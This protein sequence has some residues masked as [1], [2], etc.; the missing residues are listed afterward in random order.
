MITEKALTE[1]SIIAKELEGV[2]YKILT[3]GEFKKERVTIIDVTSLAGRTIMIR[4]AARGRNMARLFSF[5]DFIKE[6]Q[7]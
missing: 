1:W 4:F 7:K 2:A 5:E 3:N 6:A